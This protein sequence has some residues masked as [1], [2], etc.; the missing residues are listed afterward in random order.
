MTGAAPKPFGGFGIA[1]PT[2]KFEAVGCNFRLFRRWLWTSLSDDEP[3]FITSI[4]GRVTGDEVC[5]F[6]TARR[7]KTFDVMIRSDQNIEDS[8]RRAKEFDLLTDAI[9]DSERQR[10]QAIQYERFDKIPPTATLFNHRGH[11]SLECEIPL[12]I[13]DRLSADLIARA[14]ETVDISVEWPFAS[15]E[16]D[17]GAW[18]FHEWE[19]LRGY[20]CNLTWLTPLAE[21]HSQDGKLEMAEH[22][23]QA[24][25]SAAAERVGK[26]L[27]ADILAKGYSATCIA[28][29]ILV[30]ALLLGL[31]LRWLIIL[32]VVLFC[33]VSTSI[34]GFCFASVARGGTITGL[35][36]EEIALSLKR[37]RGE[38]KRVR[39]EVEE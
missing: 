8:W 30:V 28:A 32:A 17:D 15:I 31:Q 23:R 33:L 21:T 22:P 7:S 20:I 9:T 13:L 37:G 6:G 29:A 1:H 39:V 38:S 19:Q 25:W 18:G 24:E 11:R 16:A 12:P 10:I 35:M 5:V 4:H 3:T 34:A 26:K 27:T 2:R 14:V 36:C